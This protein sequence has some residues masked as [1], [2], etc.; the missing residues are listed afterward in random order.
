M[1]GTARSGHPTMP[2]LNPEFFLTQIVWLAISF[3]V[4]YLILWRVALPRVAEVL[5][6][7]QDKI[8]DDLE[9]AA[10]LKAEAEAALAT[11]EKTLSDAR[12]EAQSAM[13]EV[14]AE[15]A[16]EAVRR[17][18]ELSERLNREI[19]A[20]EDRI[21]AAKKQAVGSIAAIA[22]GAATRATERLVGRAPDTKAVEA[23]VAASL[24]SGEK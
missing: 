15:L 3:T 2:Q 17:N 4:L 12:S 20:G 21:A 16:T 5:E 13:R 7:R 8:D 24:K 23:A 11:Y 18:A 14:A 6:T 19:K 10:R 1:A 22:T 9:K